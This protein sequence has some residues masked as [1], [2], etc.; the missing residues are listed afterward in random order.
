MDA[1]QIVKAARKASGLTQESLASLAGVQQPTVSAVERGHQDPTLQTVNRLLNAIGGQ[2]TWLP[3]TRL[4]ATAAAL[5]ITEALDRREGDLSVEWPILQLADDLAASPPALRAALSVSPA[6]KTGDRR[7]DAAIAG[8]VEYRL[9]Q[10]GVEPPEWVHETSRNSPK[11]WLVCGIET[12]RD[13]VRESTPPEL[14]RH[15]VLISDDDLIS[16]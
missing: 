2:V 3:T 13:S 8:L 11:E 10:V 1:R 7:Y 14:L 15:G 16:V 9:R 12:I 4:T 5:L 6:P